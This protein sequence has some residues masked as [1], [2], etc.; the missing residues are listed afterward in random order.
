MGKV[1]HLGEWRSVKRKDSKDQGMKGR[2][3]EREEKVS[4]V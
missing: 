3:R 2:K 1:R 4:S